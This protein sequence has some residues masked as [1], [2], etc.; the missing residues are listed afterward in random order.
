MSRGR[1]AL[2]AQVIGLVHEDGVMIGVGG[3]ALGLGAGDREAERARR[4]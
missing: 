1:A 4:G 2:V 3:D